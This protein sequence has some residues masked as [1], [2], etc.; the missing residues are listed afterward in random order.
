[1][2]EE[3]RPEAQDFRVVHAGFATIDA[4]DDVE[5]GEEEPARP[6]R[7]QF[8]GGVKRPKKQQ[9]PDPNDSEDSEEEDDSEEDSDD[10]SDDDAAA[11]IRQTKREA[12]AK[13][14]EDSKARRRDTKET[15][16]RPKVNE[17]SDLGGLRGGLSSGGRGGGNM[18]CFNCGG[19]HRKSECPKLQQQRGGSSG[20]G[21]Q[22]GSY[23]RF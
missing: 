13:A 1:V 10:D 16:R 3:R 2:Q 17:D 15:P 19:N 11:F 21:R 22:S 20:R 7:M 14:K 12:A 8:G 5:S 23:K 6:V 18:S 4:E 9:Q